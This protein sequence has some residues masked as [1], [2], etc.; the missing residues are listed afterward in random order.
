MDFDIDSVQAAIDE[1]EKYIKGLINI[2]YEMT[3]IPADI[4]S[5]GVN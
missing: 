4:L 3:A 5:K 1:Y 2:V